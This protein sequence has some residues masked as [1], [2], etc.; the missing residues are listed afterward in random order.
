MGRFHFFSIGFI[1]K[2][3]YGSTIGF[4]AWEREFYIWSSTRISYSI[5]RAPLIWWSWDDWCR[6]VDCHQIAMSLSLGLGSGQT[7]FCATGTNCWNLTQGTTSS[8]SEWS[9]DDSLDF[10]YYSSVSPRRCWI[11][12]LGVFLS[13]TTSDRKH[14]P[15]FLPPFFFQRPALYLYMLLPY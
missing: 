7:F 2:K 4:T 9:C 1:E 3:V 5:S 8:L 6:V 15:A 10:D 12:P 11:F 13:T 14:Q